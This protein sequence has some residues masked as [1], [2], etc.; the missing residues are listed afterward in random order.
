MYYPLYSSVKSTEVFGDTWSGMVVSASGSAS[1]TSD[2]SQSTA[3][4]IA[5]SIAL[6][7][8]MRH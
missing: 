5:Q 2:L 3:D 6:K 4:N 7:T 8:Q 1:A